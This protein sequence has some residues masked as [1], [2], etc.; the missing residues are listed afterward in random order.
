MSIPF[1]LAAQL[2]GRQLH[3]A[4]G[5]QQ[6]LPHMLLQHSHPQQQQ[7]DTSS[8]NYQ[9]T[10]H[11]NGKNN[12]SSAAASNQACLLVGNTS[13]TIAGAG[14]GVASIIGPSEPHPHSRP[15][16]QLVFEN[17]TIT[18]VDRA[19]RSAHNSPNRSN[20]SSPTPNQLV[21]ANMS[22]LR[23]YNQAENS[24]PVSGSKFNQLRGVPDSQNP[25]HY[26]ISALVPLLL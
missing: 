19:S 15:C 5:S 3:S 4:G 1:G 11:N 7:M 9:T 21:R 18:M 14:E 20:L 6:S 10:L 23:S 13:S 2:T 22:N 17:G 8:L 25:K 12:S 16:G 24:S 26:P